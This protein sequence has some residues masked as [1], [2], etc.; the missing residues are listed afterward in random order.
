MIKGYYIS[1][2]YMGWVGDRY[3]LF[4]TDQEY[5]EYISD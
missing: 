1:C 2:G 3:M 5:I 4:S